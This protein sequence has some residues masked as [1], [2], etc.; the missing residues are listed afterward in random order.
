MSHLKYLTC[1]CPCFSLFL[2]GLP[3]V[4]ISIKPET[5]IYIGETV[6]LECVTASRSDWSYSWFK[7]SPQTELPTDGQSKDG[8]I[9][10]ITDASELDQ[11]EYWC[12]GERWK[13]NTSSLMSDPIYLTVSGEPF[14]AI[15]LLPILAFYSY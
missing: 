1:L 9:L 13:S 4:S 10:T 15:S 14:A 5:P 8:N 6:T 2:S 7:G 11:E 3:K 12:Q